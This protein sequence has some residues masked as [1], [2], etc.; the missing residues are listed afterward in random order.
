MTFDLQCWTTN[1]QLAPCDLTITAEPAVGVAFAFA[2]ALTML[3]F[4][5][6]LY[7]IGRSA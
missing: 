5:A 3:G 7:L 6:L 1:P 2:A 4:F